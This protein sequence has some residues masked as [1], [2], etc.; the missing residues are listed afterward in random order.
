PRDAGSRSPSR[1]STKRTRK[2]SSTRVVRKR[3]LGR[4]PS[5]RRASVGSRRLRRT[6]LLAL[7][8]EVM[9]KARGPAFP[10]VLLCVC[11]ALGRTA[12]ADH[13]PNPILFVTHVPVPGDFTAATSVFGNHQPD[14]QSTGRGGDLYIRYTDGTLKNLT[15]TAGYGVA[16]GFQ[17]ATSI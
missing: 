8:G 11:A 16:S 10:T 12:P 6:V 1:S 2:K 17:G 15:Q 14:L 9:S 4:G 5:R 13:L 3:D 7:R